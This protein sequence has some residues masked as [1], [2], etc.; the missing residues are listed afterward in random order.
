MDERVV[1]FAR[2]QSA[3]KREEVDAMVGPLL[4][5]TTAEQRASPKGDLWGRGFLASP[6]LPEYMREVLL[7]H[8]ERPLF[9]Q[10]TPPAPRAWPVR[11]WQGVRYRV[12]AVRHRLGEIIAGD[13]F[14]DDY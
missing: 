7:A 3:A 13:T 1:K 11:M 8:A 2:F 6:S 12:W 4:R 10:S 9:F 14:G 5:N